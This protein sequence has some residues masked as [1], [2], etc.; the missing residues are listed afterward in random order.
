M[1][2]LVKYGNKPEQ[3]EIRQ[4]PVP[5]IGDDDILLETK[6]AGICGWDIEMWQHKMT[7]QFNVP[8]IQGHEF[9][10]IIKETGKNVKDFK[11]GQRVVCEKAA[12]ICGK[13][14]QCRTGK[15]H[16]CAERKGFGYGVNG[17]FADFVKV[18]ARCLH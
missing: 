7:T 6:A 18:P 3:L 17:A 2:A 14:P 13:C 5:V 12:E 4:M 11:I 10:G 9:C 16:L 15:Y 1:K 8:V